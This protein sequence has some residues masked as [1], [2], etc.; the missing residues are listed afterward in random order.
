MS[1]NVQPDM[2]RMLTAAKTML[3]EFEFNV[4]CQFKP[5]TKKQIMVKPNFC[6]I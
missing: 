6:D 4:W 5:F 1:L 2:K 3:F